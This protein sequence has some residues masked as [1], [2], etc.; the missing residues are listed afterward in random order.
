MNSPIVPPLAIYV[1]LPWCVR[2]CPYCDFNSHQVNGAIPESRYLDTLIRDLELQAEAV[3][4]REVQTVFIGG[5]TPSLFHPQAIGRLLSAIGSRLACAADLEVTMEANPGTIERG[6]FAEYKSAGVNRV[7]L[8]GQSFNARHLQA[9]GRIHSN[10]ETHTAVEEL[11]TAGIAN[12]NIDLMYALPGQS[13]EEAL[14]DV[15]T[16]I[17]LRPAHLSHYQLTLE[18]GT[19]F[20]HRP[21]SL[22]D[23]DV[24]WE[25]QLRCQE[26]MAEHGFTQ[27]EIS[28]YASPDRRCRHNLNYW[29]FG[30]YLGLG[31]GAHGKITRMGDDGKTVV[32]RTT[33]IKS[34]KQYMDALENSGALPDS[35]PVPSGDLPFEFM[36]NA[37]RLVQGFDAIAFESRTGLSLTDIRS[38]LDSAHARGLLE[39]VSDPPGWRPTPTGL[40][41]L[42]DLQMTFL[43]PKG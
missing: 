5:G 4:G 15:R 21:P 9:L 12:F 16:A 35:R 31:A 18:P 11:H 36:L 10:A 13:L 29:Q 40:R 37:L 2:K 38:S 39:A 22:P 8:G 26:L 27:Y 1:H 19:A 23:D 32:T 17:T 24:S 25:M 7:S 14:S 33:H 6:R 42:N 3:A 43:P 41:F 34:P 28:A 30:D 20:F